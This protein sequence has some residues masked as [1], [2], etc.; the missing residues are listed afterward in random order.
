M[1]IQLILINALFI[2]IVL[3]KEINALEQVIMIKFVEI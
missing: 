1:N 3:I 2:H